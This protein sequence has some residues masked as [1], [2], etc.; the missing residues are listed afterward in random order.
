[1]PLVAYHGG[2]EFADGEDCR[3]PVSL[4]DLG[5]TVADLLNVE[6]HEHWRGISFAPVFAGGEHD[7]EYAISELCHRG[8]D[9]GYEGDVQ[10]EKA[11]VSVRTADW[12]YIRNRQKRVRELYDLAVDP[13]ETTNVYDDNPEVAAE[14]EGIATERLESVTGRRVADV[15][16][17]EDVKERLAELGYSE[18]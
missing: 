14:L 12:K 4:A 9:E 6:T 5:P 1:M 15:D 13:G 10:P 2:D 7:R 8:L 18:G 3:T 16:V 11:V 17:S